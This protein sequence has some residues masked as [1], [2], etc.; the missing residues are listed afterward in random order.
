MKNVA[1]LSSE[2][3]LIGFYPPSVGFLPGFLSR[4]EEKNMCERCK[5]VKKITTASSAE[6]SCVSPSCGCSACYPLDAN[7]NELNCENTLLVLHSSNPPALSLSLPL[8]VCTRPSDTTR[9]RRRLPLTIFTARFNAA[10]IKLAAEYYTTQRL[11]AGQR[12]TKHH[13]L[14]FFS[15]KEI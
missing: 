9:P 6:T 11:S 3:R 7:F 1:E 5:E 13:R 10:K 4:S 15:L 2:G 8:P 14:S 12:R